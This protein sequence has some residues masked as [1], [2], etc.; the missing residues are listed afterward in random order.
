MTHHDT[1]GHDDDQ[2]EGAPGKPSQ[3]EGERNP[4]SQGDQTQSPG[5]KPSQAEGERETVEEDLNQS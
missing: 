2:T 4:G 3:A 1:H 5:G